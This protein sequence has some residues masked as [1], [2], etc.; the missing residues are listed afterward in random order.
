MT[1]GI[2]TIENAPSRATLAAF[3]AAPKPSAE[4]R[5]QIKIG[6]P[7]PPKPPEPPKR[8]EPEARGIIDRIKRDGDQ[9]IVIRDIARPTPKDAREL[10]HQL[11]E[12]GYGKKAEEIFE[13][14]GYDDKKVRTRLD[15]LAAED[16]K[17][18]GYFLKSLRGEG[19]S[20]YESISDKENKVNETFH[21]FQRSHPEDHEYTT[22]REALRRKS[23][24]L[25]EE[26]SEKMAQNMQEAFPS[27][28]YLVHG[29]SVE[30]ALGIAEDG[31]LRSVGSKR[32][33]QADFRGKGGIS[34]I[35]FSYDGVGALPG[36]Q[37]HMIMFVTSPELTLTDETKLTVP[38]RAAPNELQLVDRGYDREKAAQSDARYEFLVEDTTWDYG[39]LANYLTDA[40]S[41]SAII[42]DLSKL[43]NGELD[44]DSVR[45]M[46]KVEDEKFTVNPSIIER[47]VSPGLVW[48]DYLLRHTDQGKALGKELANCTP[49]EILKTNDTIGEAARKPLYKDLHS[50]EDSMQYNQAIDIPLSDLVMMVPRQD[51]DMWIDVYARL[52]KDPRAIIAYSPIT[53]PRVPNWNQPE[54]HKQRANQV[55]EGSFEASGVKRPSLPFSDIIGRETADTDLAGSAIRYLRWDAIKD[56]REL[57]KNANGE[58]VASRANEK[59]A[60]SKMEETPNAKAPESIVQPTEQNLSE[61]EQRFLETS[62][63][64]GKVY[65]SIVNEYIGKGTIDQEALNSLPPQIRARMEAIAKSAQVHQGQQDKTV[66]EQNL[67]ATDVLKQYEKK[68]AEVLTDPLKY[69]MTRLGEGMYSIDMDYESFRKIFH[70]SS[71][72]AI[73]A[74]PKDGIP[75]IITRRQRNGEERDVTDPYLQENIPHEAHHIVWS[76][77]QKD[78]VINTSE[79]DPFVKQ[80]FLDFQDEVIAR[81]VSNGKLHGSTMLSSISEEQRRAMEE[82]YPNAVQK[83]KDISPKLNDELGIIDKRLKENSV[84]QKSDLLLALI[85]AGN[86]AELQTNI[87]IVKSIVDKTSSKS[88]SDSAGENKQ[89][90]TELDII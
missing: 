40:S 89:N 52:G 17:E 34:G 66:Q 84:V 37:R 22:R 42:R 82:K 1:D 12:Y 49:Q 46:Y 9:D 43:K 54:G 13:D 41:N 81:A 63:S 69:S 4:S 14:V 11:K 51:L 28:N 18:Y 21:T 88:E 2:P 31:A 35:S 80:A 23:F 16:P 3:D 38:L 64:V 32:K 10:L 56:A 6:S 73:A 76:N 24:V 83:I 67:T 53:G 60:K 50:L 87:K 79:T 7:E 36:T 61:E 45:Q 75:F 58:L 47:D 44:I 33:D 26:V 68:F 15:Q 48:A 62:R 86:F 57:T 74:R 39:E 70:S 8:I 29:T 78:G 72:N 90:I 59:A 25:G 65:T 85:S 27:G 71:A 20:F 77:A 55:I 19:L 30:G 5:P